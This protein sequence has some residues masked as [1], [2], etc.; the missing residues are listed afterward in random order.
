V[1]HQCELFFEMGKPGFCIVMHT[2]FYWETIIFV[3]SAHDFPSVKR[4]WLGDIRARQT[5]PYHFLWYIRTT[6][7]RPDSLHDSC[8]SRFRKRRSP[9]SP[10]TRG[11]RVGSCYIA[12]AVFPCRNGV[13]VTGGFFIDCVGR[14]S[15]SNSDTTGQAISSSPAQSSPGG[16][17][18][19][20][21]FFI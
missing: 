1:Q 3:H 18:S 14:T 6:K 21:W 9:C 8:L 7:V 2:S 5:Q 20:S 13:D 10:W 15:P 16:I 17:G 11:R 12:S 19:F 4:V